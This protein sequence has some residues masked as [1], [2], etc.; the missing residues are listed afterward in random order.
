M[1]DLGLLVLS[2]SF[3]SFVMVKISYY[4]KKKYHDYLI[5]WNN[6]LPL[7]YEKEDFYIHTICSKF[8]CIR[9]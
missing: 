4:A 9:S 7:Y 1:T 3:I 6:W 2:G 8:D 5:N